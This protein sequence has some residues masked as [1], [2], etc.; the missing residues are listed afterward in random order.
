MSGDPQADVERR[1]AA[2]HL[3]QHP[4]TRREDDADTFRLIRRHE[5]DLDRWF[6]QRLGYRLHVDADTA[7]LQKSTVLPWS[8]PLRTGTGRAL[9]SVEHTLL[10]LVLATTVAGPAVISLRDLVD[11]AIRCTVAR[12]PG[13]DTTVSSPEGSLTLRNLAVALTAA[14]HHGKE[15]VD[16]R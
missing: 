15:A 6:T 12:T 9:T 7:R 1:L 3:V 13:R 14:E 10:A 16:V 11:G 8:R 4:L 5:A 2:R